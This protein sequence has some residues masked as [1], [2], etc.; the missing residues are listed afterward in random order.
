M[1]LGISSLVKITLWRSTLESKFDRNFFQGTLTRE[2]FPRN[3]SQGI[4]HRNFCEGT[5]Q[6]E[7]FPGN[8]CRGTFSEGKSYWET[9]SR[10]LFR[11]NFSERTL[12]GE[13]F[14][15]YFFQ[16]TFSRELYQRELRT[17]SKGANSGSGTLSDSKK[18]DQEA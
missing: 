5:F 13:L 9:L 14:P 4:F 15:G 7:V 16:G 2:L 17:S 1:N 8:F 6:K 18:A 3:F 10:E 12:S 11:G